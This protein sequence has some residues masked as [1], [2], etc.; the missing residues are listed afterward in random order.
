MLSYCFSKKAE[1][2]H[3]V[4]ILHSGIV[5][6]TC[7]LKEKLSLFPYR[8]ISGHY[9]YLDEISEIQRKEVEIKE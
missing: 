8:K 5:N 7:G 4:W 1:D 6:F 3:K 2:S 9:H